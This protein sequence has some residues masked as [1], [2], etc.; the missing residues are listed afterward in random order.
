MNI[1]AVP[2]VSGSMKGL[3]LI[4]SGNMLYFTDAMTDHFS[5]IGLK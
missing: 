4:S 3:S 5:P 2:S 1:E